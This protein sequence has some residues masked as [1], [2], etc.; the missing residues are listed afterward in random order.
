M[1]GP[2]FGGGQ[3]LGVGRAWTG[4]APE[5]AGPALFLMSPAARALTGTTLHVDGGYH[6]MGAPL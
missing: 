4:G 3:P 2:A 5:A 6:A 1:S